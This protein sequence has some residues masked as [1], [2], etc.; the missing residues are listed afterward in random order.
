MFKRDAEMCDAWLSA[1]EPVLHDPDLGE[2]IPEVEELI[3][4][5]EDFEK[6]VEAQEE[7]FAALKRITMVIT[8]SFPITLDIKIKHHFS[9][10]ANLPSRGKKRKRLRRLRRREPTKRDKSRGSARK[11]KKSQSN[12]AER[13]TGE[14]LRRCATEKIRNTCRPSSTS[15]VAKNLEDLD[16]VRAVASRNSLTNAELLVINNVLSSFHNRLRVINF[17]FF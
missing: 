15:R 17:L 11:S 7:K 9:W 3:R 14:G 6:T 16:S 13:M 1:R 2:S 12:V 4:K 5:H 10:S 8:P